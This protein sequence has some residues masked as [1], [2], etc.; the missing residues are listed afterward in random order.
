MMSGSD[1]PKR[2]VEHSSTIKTIADLKPDP[3]NARKHGERNVA[4]GDPS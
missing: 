2:S 3:K 4:A 1:K